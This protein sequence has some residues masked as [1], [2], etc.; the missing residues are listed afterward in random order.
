MGSEGFQAEASIEWT[1][2]SLG[3]AVPR[4]TQ[5]LYVGFRMNIS[6]RALTA[7]LW[8]LFP[9]FTEASRVR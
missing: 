4:P 5:K 7:Q 9:P 2:Y 1:P 6:H 8:A 3:L